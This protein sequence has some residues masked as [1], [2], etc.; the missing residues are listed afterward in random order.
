M[1]TWIYFM[2]SVIYYRQRL[3]QD[4]KH[5]YA[6]KFIMGHFELACNNVS[7]D[8]NVFLEVSKTSLHIT[9]CI[10]IVSLCTIFLLFCSTVDNPVQYEIRRY[11]FGI[12]QMK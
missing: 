2:F 9:Y 3:L 6:N 12:N 11:R 10:L 4:P 7:Y 5:F 8:I 1:E